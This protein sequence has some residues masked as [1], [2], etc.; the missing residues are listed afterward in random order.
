MN[1]LTLKLLLELEV[2]GDIANNK[3]LKLSSQ[4]IL[5]LTFC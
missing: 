5:S 2:I 3:S 1:I 4:I